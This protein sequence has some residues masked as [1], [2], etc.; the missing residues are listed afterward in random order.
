MACGRLFS[1]EEP[2][3]APFRESNTTV[4]TYLNKDEINY[5]WK[6]RATGNELGSETEGCSNSWRS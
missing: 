5:I 4:A 3:S 6:K 1:N 2:N